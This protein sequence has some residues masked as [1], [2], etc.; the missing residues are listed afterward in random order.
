M[1]SISVDTLQGESKI[2]TGDICYHCGFPEANHKFP[3]LCSKG[4]L[5]CPCGHPPVDMDEVNCLSINCPYKKRHA[6]AQRKNP[7]YPLW[8]SRDYHIHAVDIWNKTVRQIW[9]EIGQE[10]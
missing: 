9:K 1:E 3:H 7:E 4:V 10:L 6:E 2:Y 8:E 5:K